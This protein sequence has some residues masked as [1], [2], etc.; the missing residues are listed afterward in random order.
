VLYPCRYLS[1]GGLVCGI[2]TAGF[3][4][5]LTLQLLRTFSVEELSLLPGRRSKRGD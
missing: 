5:L 3:A 4:Y 1:W 2:G